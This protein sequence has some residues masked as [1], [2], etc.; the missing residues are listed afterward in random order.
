[1]IPEISC[2]VRAIEVGGLSNTVKFDP[3]R[4]S[5]WQKLESEHRIY[6]YLGYRI[7]SPRFLTEIS[8]ESIAA[9]TTT[10]L[11][12]K[13]YVIPSYRSSKAKNLLNFKLCCQLCVV[14]EIKIQLLQ[15]RFYTLMFIYIILLFMV[16]FVASD[17]VLLFLAVRDIR[18]CTC[19]PIENGRFRLGHIRDENATTEELL[20]GN[21]IWTYVSP[22]F[23]MI[24]VK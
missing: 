22:E 8:M 17:C 9:S 12:N 18:Q 1:M 10:M 5:Q 19:L 20:T 11:R 6:A 3:N 21:S 16:R 14:H 2:F 15:G 7:A 24:E 23:S 13:P 4:P